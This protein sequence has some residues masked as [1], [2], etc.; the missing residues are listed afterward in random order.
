MFVGAIHYFIHNGNIL[1]AYKTYYFQDQNNSLGLKTLSKEML[2]T[3]ENI[4]LFHMSHVY[5][6]F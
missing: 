3:K 5:Y 4:N 6:E 2:F 1:K